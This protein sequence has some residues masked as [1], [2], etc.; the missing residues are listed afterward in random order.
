MSGEDLTG[1]GAPADDGPLWGGRFSK[2]PA[3][4]AF[5]LGASLDFDIELL[6]FDIEASVAHVW[7]LAGAGLLTEE[8]AVRLEEALEAVPDRLQKLTP[9]DLAGIEDVHLLVERLVTDQLGDLGAKLHA[10]RS[11]N[12]LVVADFRLWSLGACGMVAEK[13][14]EL[15]AVLSQRAREGAEWVMPGLTHDR[16]AQVVTLG[17]TLAAHGFALR[18]DIERLEDWTGRRRS[19]RWAPERSPLRRSAL[20]R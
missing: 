10:G 17:Y 12:D 11:R 15:I 4:E 13:V 2:P 18:R 8:E 7:A 19:R 20:T 16:P 1:G 5:D 6:D 3:P 9:E 14:E